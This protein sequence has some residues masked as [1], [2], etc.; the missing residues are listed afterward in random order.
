MKIVL[1]SNNPGKITEFQTLLVN[2]SVTIIPQSQ[3]NVSD[4]AEIASTF[5]ENALIKAR[6]AATMTGLPAIADDSGLV[7]DA[8]HGAPGIYSARYAGENADSQQNITKLLGELAGVPA[9][10]RGACF[11]CVIVY[12]SY[13]D[14]PIPIICQGSWRGSIL[15]EPQGKNGFGYDPIFYVPNHQGSAAELSIAEKNRISHRG[16]AL[17]QF[18][19]IFS[20]K[21]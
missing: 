17:Q 10:Q 2:F 15:F 11:Q 6:H 20:A 21:S 3:L 16:Q 1:A 14:D 12:L 8:L 5:V 13:A 9:A 19:Q 4:V 7:V 18:I